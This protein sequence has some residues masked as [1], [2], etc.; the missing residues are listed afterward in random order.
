MDATKVNSVLELSKYKPGDKPY[1]VVFAPTGAHDAVVRPEDEWAFSGEA[2]PKVLY[3]RKLL[4]GIWTSR[5]AVP[6]LNASDF[7]MVLFF[8]T[9]EITVNRFEVCDVMHC[10][11][12]GEFL[13][14]NTCEEWMPESLL[15]SSITAAKREQ[16]RIKSMIL[17]WIT[18]HP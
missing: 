15:F 12:T 3:D 9:S 11:H 14:Q 8:L 16:K 17:Q 5:F 6:K 10:K 18:S 7:E 1:W 4:K 13:Y 2:H